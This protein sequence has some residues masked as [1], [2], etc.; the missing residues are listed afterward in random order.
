MCQ[1]IRYMFFPWAVSVS[2]NE[3]RRLKDPNT[4][5][6]TLEHLNALFGTGT[7]D[8]VEEIW[9]FFFLDFPLFPLKNAQ[10]T[11]IPIPLLSQTKHKLHKKGYFCKLT[12][13]R[14][15]FRN[16]L[17][18]TND[19]DLFGSMVIHYHWPLHVA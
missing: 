19:S 16:C 10:S 6:S 7:N 14:T 13:V 15:L 11:Q 9:V 2:Q 4:F 8:K 18:L 3:Q 5:P 12:H 17:F 1:N